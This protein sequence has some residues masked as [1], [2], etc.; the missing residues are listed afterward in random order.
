MNANLKSVQWLTVEEV[1]EL[2]APQ[3][4][5][6]KATIMRELQ[7]ALYKLEKA[8]TER[9]FGY[10]AMRKPLS[11]APPDADLPSKDTL[12][13]REFI[14]AFCDKEL[15]AMP[16]FWFKQIPTGPSFPGRPSIMSEIVQELEGRAKRGELERTLAAEAKALEQWA[17]ANPEFVGKQLPR[18]PSIRNG[19]RSAY[20]ILKGE[21]LR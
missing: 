16:L 21:F 2:W 14:E 13:N 19:V 9:Y 15:W 12:I 4:S 8:K 3:L 7:Y 17:Q 6:P 18:A 11:E 1:S 10:E 20:N 5:I